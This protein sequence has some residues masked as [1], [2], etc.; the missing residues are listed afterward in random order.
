MALAQGLSTNLIDIA[1]KSHLHML[2]PSPAA[3]SVSRSTWTVTPEYR[4]IS[5]LAKESVKEEPSIISLATIA[6]IKVLALREG[7]LMLTDH[8]QSSCSK[9]YWL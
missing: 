6:F 7:S 3:Y 1:W 5:G 2:H 4:P 8:S 9:K